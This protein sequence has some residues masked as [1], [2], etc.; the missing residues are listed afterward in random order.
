MTRWIGCLLPALF[1]V[2]VS[3][4]GGEESIPEYMID[5]PRVLAVAVEDPETVPGAEV[6]MRLLTGGRQ[7]DQNQDQDVN[8]MVAFDPPVI[9]VAA[10]NDPCVV[11]IPDASALS[12][13]FAENSWFDIPVLSHT[14]IQ[15]KNYYAEKMLRISDEPVGKNPEIETIDVSFIEAGVLKQD[16]SIAEAGEEIRFQGDNCPVNIA[17]TAVPA[18]LEAADD[19]DRLIFSWK[20]S[21]SKNGSSHRLYTNTDTSDVEKILGQGAKAADYRQSVVFSLRGKNR[22]SGIQYGVYDIYLIVRDKA[23]DAQ[24]RS[25]DRLGLNFFY[26]TLVIESF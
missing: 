5:G 1:F 19:N 12:D 11:M 4:G 20:V 6:A 15:G 10:Y 24:D 22:K 14:M 3:C 25:E 7:V 8:W 2:L 21:L 13:Y 9:C 17:F 16:I 26:F 23:S 18:G